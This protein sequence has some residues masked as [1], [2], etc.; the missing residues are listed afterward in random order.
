MHAIESDMLL[1]II[2]LE[3]EAAPGFSAGGHR[4]QVLEFFTKP[5]GVNC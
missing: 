3:S 2:L 1:E 5:G 4:R